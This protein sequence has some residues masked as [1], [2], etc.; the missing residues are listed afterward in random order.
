MIFINVVKL[1]LRSSIFSHKIDSCLST[2]GDPKKR[3]REEEKKETEIID[4]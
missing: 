2:G 3:V 1:F 4:R